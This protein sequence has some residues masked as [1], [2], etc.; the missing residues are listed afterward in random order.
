MSAPGAYSIEVLSSKKDIEGKR[1][2]LGLSYGDSWQQTVPA[3]DYVVVRHMSAEG[4][5][6]EVPVTIKA[7]ERSEITVQ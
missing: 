7:G 6:K 1:K 2:S 5:E 4:Q 3:G